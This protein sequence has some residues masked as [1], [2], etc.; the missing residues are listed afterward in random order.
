MTFFSLAAALLLEQWRPLR[1]GN[2]LYTA[3]SRY[4]NVVARNFDAG[5]YRDGVFSWLLAVVPVAIVT[6][7]VYLVLR[8]MS[9][10]WHGCGTSPCFIS[11]SVSVTS[12]ISTTKSWCAAR[13][14]HCTRT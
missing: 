1:S 13:Q 6:L 9:G 7:A 14:R 3:Y 4:V 2:R 5:Q 11:R 8:S 12:A 10:C